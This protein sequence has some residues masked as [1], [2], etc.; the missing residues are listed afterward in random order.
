MAKKSSN[1][2]LGHTPY[3]ATEAALNKSRIA[4]REAEKA[5][6]KH[7]LEMME[8]QPPPE[9]QARRRQAVVRV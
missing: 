2:E 5:N 4:K 9:S 3:A 1:Y 8:F 6:P 7:K